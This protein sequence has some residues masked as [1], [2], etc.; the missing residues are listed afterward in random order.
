[1]YILQRFTEGY[2]AFEADGD[3]GCNLTCPLIS[4]VTLRNLLNSSE[5]HLHN[6]VQ[7]ILHRADVTIQKIIVWHTVN[8]HL[9]TTSSP[10]LPFSM[11]VSNSFTF[12][13]LQLFEILSPFSG[14]TTRRRTGTGPSS[15]QRSLCTEPDTS[16]SSSLSVLTIHSLSK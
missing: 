10:H 2:W 3:L 4:C 1:M 11:R 5:S 15:S 14:H 6:G 12:L 13:L 9:V 8:A 16:L 7:I